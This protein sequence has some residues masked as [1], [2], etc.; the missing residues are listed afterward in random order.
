MQRAYDKHGPEAFRFDIIEECSPEELDEREMYWI[1]FYDA[2]SNGYNQTEG[3]GG[4][5]GYVF[6]EGTRRK[7]SVNHRDVSGAN[8]PMYG[9]S[10]RECM[11]EE[12]YK[13]HCESLRGPR[14]ERRGIPMSESAK[15]KLSQSRVEFYKTHIHPRLGVHHTQKAKD[16][17]R[18]TKEKNGTLHL[19]YGDGHNAKSVVCLNTGKVY[20]SL[21]RAAEDTGASKNVISMCIHDHAE[22]HSSGVGKDGKRLVWM[23]LDDYKKLLPEEVSTYVEIAQEPTSG[24]RNCNARSVRC[25][26]TGEIF[27]SAMEA[28]REYG[29]DNSSLSKCCRKE[30]RSCGKLNG[31]KLH[32]EYT[33]T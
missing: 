4:N 17:M 31:Q 3:G 22:H 11:S 24:A 10:Y 32:W 1:Q 9:K 25:V 13:A 23:L 28:A 18:A 33:T 26:E 27:G 15:K 7:M 16:K 30:L 14:P 5:R 20:D 21:V 2:F 8:N 29:V 19:Y 12:A 6:S